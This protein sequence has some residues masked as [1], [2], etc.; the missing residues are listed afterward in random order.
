MDDLFLAL[1]PADVERALAARLKAARRGRGWT[2]AEIARRSG[3]SL[4]TIARLERSGQGQ[5]SSL[6]R[7]CAALGR[8]DD[9]D[10]LLRPAAPTSLDELRRRSR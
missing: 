1:T 3:L 4:A 6:T 9:F 7:L 5:I 8:L 10:A 2:Q